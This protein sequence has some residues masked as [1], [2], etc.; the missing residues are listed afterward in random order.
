VPANE[1]ALAARIEAVLDA[2]IQAQRIV[3]AVVLVARNEQLVYHRA[4]GFSDREANTPV[5]EQTLFRL[6]SMSK[7]IVS[8]AALALAEDQLRNA[9]YGFEAPKK[10]AR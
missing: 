6:A 8:V 3:G 5:S 4:A 7:P 2:E 10:S 1:A 9:V